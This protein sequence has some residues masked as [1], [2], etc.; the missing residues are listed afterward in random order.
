MF[1]VESKENFYQK[2]NYVFIKQMSFYNL[3]LRYDNSKKMFDKKEEAISY[4]WLKWG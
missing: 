4:K 1:W 3:D 2:L